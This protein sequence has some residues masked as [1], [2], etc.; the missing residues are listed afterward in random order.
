MRVLITAASAVAATLATSCYEPALDDCQ[1]VCGADTTCPD[2]TACVAGVCRT[3]G[4]TGAC[5]G[6][7]GLAPDGGEVGEADAGVA[8]IDAGDACP[9]SPCDGV[10]VDLGDRC[11]VVCAMQSF[12]A[13]SASCAASG[14]RLAIVDS[15]G[16]RAA[17]KAAFDQVVAWVGLTKT[18]A[19]ESGWQWLSAPA[20]DQPTDAAAH[21]PWATGEPMAN[22]LYGTLD[23]TADTAVLATS[24][25]PERAFCELMR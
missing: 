24:P 12:S 11:A 8:T 9:A 17:F 1:F 2:G 14:W 7:D 3:A 4:A 6:D 15:P 20:T 5:G 25:G 10:P 23:T 18:N 21:P 19:G 16:A 22:R 13:A